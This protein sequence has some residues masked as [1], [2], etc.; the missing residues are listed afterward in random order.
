MSTTTATT[1]VAMM[2]VWVLSESE[3]DVADDVGATVGDAVPAIADAEVAV[4]VAV[5]DVVV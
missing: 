3:S 2:T 1:T 4:A 5:P